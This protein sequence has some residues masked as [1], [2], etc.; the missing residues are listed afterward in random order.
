MIFDL[1]YQENHSCCGMQQFRVLP[2]IC[3]GYLGDIILETAHGSMVFHASLKAVQSVRVAY[4]YVLELM[5]KNQRFDQKNTN[6]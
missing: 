1:S 6:G 2:E 5:E 4:M 3:N